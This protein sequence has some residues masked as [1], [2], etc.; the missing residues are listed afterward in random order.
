MTPGSA[1]AAPFELACFPM[2]TQLQEGILAAKRGDRATAHALLLQVVTAAEDNETA[3][4]WLSGVTETWEERRICL[5]NVLTLNPDNEVAERELAK[6][7]ASAPNDERRVAA[8][9]KEQCCFACG[10]DLYPG[11]HLQTSTELFLPDTEQRSE[12]ASVTFIHESSHDDVWTSGQTLC[13]FCAHPVAE[14][15]NR[16]P[17]CKKPL[18]GWQLR[19]PKAT[20]RLYNYLVIMSALTLFTLVDFFLD[21]SL[22]NGLPLILH[23]GLLTVVLISMVIAAYFRHLWWSLRCH[24]PCLYSGSDQ[25]QS[26]VPGSPGNPFAAVSGMDMM[27]LVAVSIALKLIEIVAALAVLGYGA[28]A[29]GV[30]F[31]RRK[32]RFTA[33]LDKNVR[34]AT[35][36]HSLARLLAEQGMWASA[37]IHWEHAAAHAPNHAQYQRELGMAYHRLGF[38]ERSL[39]ALQSAHRLANHLDVKAEIALLIAEI[40]A[41]KATG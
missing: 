30:D 1:V 29:V 35:Q 7:N 14:D 13:A 18:I 27:L 22:K 25:W 32:V 12:P 2:N 37:I 8:P 17:Q 34:D 28:F 16:C 20:P 41:T 33:Q 31:D 39:D 4:L 10:R 24:Y 9:A 11:H 21:I 38:T 3:W 36:F 15:A 26:V 40:K 6:L 19:Y 5:E 23:H